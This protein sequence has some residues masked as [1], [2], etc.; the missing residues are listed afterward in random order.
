ME[1][2]I[3]I[4]GA[5]AEAL[6]N[7]RN[8]YDKDWLTICTPYNG[9]DFASIGQFTELDNLESYIEMHKHPYFEMCLI[10]E[11][12]CV[13]QFMNI[14]K[15]IEQGKV[16][17]ILPET[18][19]KEFPEKDEEY[20]AIWIIFEPRSIKLHLSGK[21]AE[22]EFFTV[23][24]QVLEIEYV[25][26]NIIL[27]DIEKECRAFSKWSVDII[28]TSIMQL[29]IL[30]LKNIENLSEKMKEDIT[31]NWRHYV[32]R[33]VIEYIE[34]SYTKNILLADI[35]RH[36]AISINYLNNIFKT[37][38]GRTVINYFSDY[39]IL[40]A[41][42]YLVNSSIKIKDMASLL[43]YYD[44]YHF[45]KAFKKSTGKSPSDYRKAQMDQSAR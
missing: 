31:E 8:N 29:L 27:S 24:Y 28:K 40:K 14:I 15:E 34:A 25:L 12:K 35:S 11:G 18:E 42:E 19:H 23:N 26:Y 41:K 17:I 1:S 10:L 43:G 4:F 32:V 33:E 20:M 9:Q 5:V 44:P 36:V 30:I 2:S 3:T 22:N 6:K 7:T 21:N 38:T 13:L 37:V 45:C 16:C 39:K